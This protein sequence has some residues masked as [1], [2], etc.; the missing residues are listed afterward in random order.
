MDLWFYQSLLDVI[1][2]DGDGK[3]KEILQRFGYTTFMIPDLKNTLTSLH[4]C[5]EMS[6]I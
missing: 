5:F 2:N 3:Q 6:E 4:Y 1:L